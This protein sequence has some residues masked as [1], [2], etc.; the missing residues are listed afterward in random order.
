MW[1]NM[2]E[3]SSRLKFAKWRWLS[4]AVSNSSII[5]I[6][7]S[8]L[9]FTSQ[10]CPS[11]AFGSLGCISVCTVFASEVF[12]LLLA[13]GP[14]W[15]SVKAVAATM[16]CAHTCFLFWPDYTHFLALFHNNYPKLHNIWSK[17]D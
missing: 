15:Y 12:L 5:F 8:W 2:H 6:L 14:I 1:S 7:H 16:R 17:F 3:I 9:V 4:L 10:R 11:L 13:I